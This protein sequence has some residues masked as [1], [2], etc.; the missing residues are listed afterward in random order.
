MHRVLL[1]F[2]LLLW[3]A[4]AP[5]SAVLAEDVSV[6][7]RMEA[8]GENTSSVRIKT[9]INGEI[10]H[11]VEEVAGEIEKHL[12]Y[13]RGNDRARVDVRV[14]SEVTPETESEVRSRSQLLEEYPP[15][16]DPREATNVSAIIVRPK[17]YIF[18]TSF[19]TDLFRYE[20]PIF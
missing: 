1:V 15:Y 11:D 5:P 10:I 13:E 16:A 14:R 18:I 2:A 6:T 4:G 12:Q 19:F 9:I 20:F 3:L 7:S 8:T 17:E